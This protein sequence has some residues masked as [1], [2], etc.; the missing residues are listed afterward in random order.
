ML[1]ASP[2]ADQIEELSLENKH[3]NLKTL[4]SYCMR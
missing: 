2:L 3:F 1:I 4:T